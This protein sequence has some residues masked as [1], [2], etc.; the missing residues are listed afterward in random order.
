MRVGLDFGTT[1]SSAA[2][3]RDGKIE[4][5]ALDPMNNSPEVLRSALFISRDGRIFMG[6]E[7][8][9]R[10]TQGNVGREVVYDRVKVGDN[11]GI[12]PSTGGIPRL[13]EHGIDLAFRA[14]GL[15]DW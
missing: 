3:V 11:A 9:D 13:L 14:L 1:N 7:A 6:R 5:V 2:V 10:Y 4:L 12:V 15:R 8:I